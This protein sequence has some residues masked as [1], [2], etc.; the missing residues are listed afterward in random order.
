MQDQ[1]SQWVG[2]YRINMKLSFYLFY[3][4]YFSHSLNRVHCP[5]VWII[6]I[7][8]QL[9]DILLGE[10]LNDVEVNCY[11][12]CCIYLYFVLCFTF[13]LFI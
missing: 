7:S 1:T 2:F 3:F 11:L 5:Y 8:L 6:V 13:T 10:K 9:D 12:N 4:I